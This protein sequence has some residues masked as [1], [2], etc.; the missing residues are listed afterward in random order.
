MQI[1]LLDKVA[2]LGSLGDQAHVKAGYARNYLIPQG[3]AVP[4][5]KRTSNSSKHVVLN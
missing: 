2:N 4:A 1:I 5:T 3:K